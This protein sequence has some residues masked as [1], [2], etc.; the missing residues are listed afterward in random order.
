MDSIANRRKAIRREIGRVRFPGNFSLRGI[1][2]GGG[3]CY[4]YTNLQDR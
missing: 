4:N 3:T 2:S 1:D